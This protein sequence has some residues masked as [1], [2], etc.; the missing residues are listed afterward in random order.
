MFILPPSDSDKIDNLMALG[1][2][3]CIIAPFTM[4]RIL[5]AIYS[6]Y[7]MSHKIRRSVV[8]QVNKVLMGEGPLISPQKIP[9]DQNTDKENLS[10]T[11][12]QSAVFAQNALSSREK[13]IALLISEGLTDKEIA[14]KLNIS[15]G[16]V[17]THNKKIFKKMNVHSRIE[18]VNKVR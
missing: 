4:K 16:T 2:T 11:S 18:L 5:R 13:Q 14:E 8:E 6:I 9:M 17:T 15:L 12:S 3:D 7:S 1:A 10:L